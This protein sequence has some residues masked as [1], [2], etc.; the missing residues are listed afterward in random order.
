MARKG[1]NGTSDIFGTSDDDVINAGN[2]KGN[3]YGGDG[4]DTITGGNGMD[5]LYGEVGD[6][7]LSGG[8]AKDMLNGGDGNDFLNGGIGKDSLFGGDGAD[9]FLFDSSALK[10]GSD[11][12]NDFVATTTVTTTNT[13]TGETTTTTT[14]N[15]RLEFHDLLDGYDPL[16]SNIA[17]YVQLKEV[18]GN[19]IVSVDRDGAAHGT[20]FTQVVTLE[21]VTGLDAATM[22][23]DGNIVVSKS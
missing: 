13:E 1:T 5:K 4:N 14:T 8:N 21:G 10:G 12:L 16:T 20:H 9:T 17:D 2:G 11:T 19:T 23:A 6:D 7:N 15:D 18:G 22:L 3:V